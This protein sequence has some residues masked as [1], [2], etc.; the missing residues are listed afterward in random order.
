MFG[1]SCSVKSTDGGP[2]LLQHCLYRSQGD[3]QHPA[4]AVGGGGVGAVLTFSG[5]GGLCTSAGKQ[6][7]ETGAG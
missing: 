3:R 1:H 7:A 5:R 4:R 2:A 6:I